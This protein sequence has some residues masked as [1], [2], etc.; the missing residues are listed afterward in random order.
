[1]FLFGGFL[2]PHGHSFLSDLINSRNR[3]KMISFIYRGLTIAGDKKSLRV[4]FLPSEVNK[5]SNTEEKINGFL[6]T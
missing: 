4:I 6:R 1:M 2:V 5:K 3:L